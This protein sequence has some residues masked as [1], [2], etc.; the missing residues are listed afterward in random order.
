MSTSPGSDVYSSSVHRP[1]NS[2]DDQTWWDN[3]GSYGQVSSG[4]SGCRTQ[5]C[6]NGSVSPMTFGTPYMQ[7]T[8]WYQ[9]LTFG[10][11]DPAHDTPLGC[12]Y[13]D[14]FG[15]TQDATPTD[16][17][18]GM[19]GYGDVA[20]HGGKKDHDG[21]SSS[22]ET[23]GDPIDTV[24]GVI[25]NVTDINVIRSDYT[26]VGWMY[27]TQ[28]GAR[29]FQPDFATQAGWN[30]SLNLGI[31]S[32]G[33]SSPGGVGPVKPWTGSLPPGSRPYNCFTDGHQ[34]IS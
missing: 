25:M 9:A 8:C 17:G 11:H 26:V 14:F 1:L 30:W 28:T 21:C 13:I 2:A 34:L 7:L 32:G 20:I 31:V 22:P 6:P 4:G 16:D 15:G 12:T 5:V 24:N 33:S 27:Q 18:R 10:V 19:R 29:Y 23:I 3:G